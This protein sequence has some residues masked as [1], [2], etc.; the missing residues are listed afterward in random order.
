MRE[1]KANIREQLLAVR[2]AISAEQKT[3]NER[4]VCKRLLAIIE[5]LHSLNPDVSFIGLYDAFGSELSLG[6]LAQQLREKGYRLAFPVAFPDGS[7]DFFS[8]DF[9]SA[10]SQ[11]SVVLQPGEVTRFDFH[12]ELPAYRRHDRSQLSELTMVAPGQLAFLVVPGVGFDAQGHRL[13]YGAGYYDRYLPRL[14]PQTPLWGAAFD[15][16]L[17]DL[18]PMEEH[19]IPLTGVVT[20]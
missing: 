12:N 8:E 20:P 4:I 10:G 13:G 17:L 2:A 14:S 1:L 16:Q 3:A 9:E 6:I 5:Q 7:M 18:L 11:P 15:E 19:D